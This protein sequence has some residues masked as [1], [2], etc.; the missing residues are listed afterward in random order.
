MR[1]SPWVEAAVTV[2]DAVTA[3]MRPVSTSPST[4]TAPRRRKA[5]A[6]ARSGAVAGGVAGVGAGARR[7]V[8][9]VCWWWSG[10][11]PSTC[12]GEVL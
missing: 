8:A 3:T 6:A 7:R 1:R 10:L 11:A 4:G 2:T 12:R 5:A 9:A